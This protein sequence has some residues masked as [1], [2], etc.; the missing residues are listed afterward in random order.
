LT[1]LDVPLDGSL[2]ESKFKD[3]GKTMM[4]VAKHGATVL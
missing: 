4:V 2:D 3:F 1:E